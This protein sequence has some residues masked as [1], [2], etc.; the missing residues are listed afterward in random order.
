MWHIYIIRCS[1]SSLYT[2]VA[3]NLAARIEQHNSGK[4]AKY[5]RG[6]LPVSLLYS[7]NSPSRSTAQQREAQ[8]K[9]LSREA[10]LSLVNARVKS[11]LVSMID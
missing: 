2:G 11:Q 8:I 6:R 5:T 7:E 1:D 10:K 9:K 3:K 4:G